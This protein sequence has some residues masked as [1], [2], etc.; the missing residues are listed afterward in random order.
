MPEPIDGRRCVITVVVG[1]RVGILRDVASAVADQDGV[2]DGISQTVVGGYFTA[3]LT[4]AFPGAVAP[5]EIRAAVAAAFGPGEAFIAVRPHARAAGDAPP[6]AGARYV[7]TIAG[8]NRPTVL[9]AVT[10][11]LARRGINIEDWNVMFDEPYVTHVG[12]ITVPRHMDIKQ[13]QD[14]FHHLMMQLG[15]TTC[16]QHENIFRATNEV[17]PITSLLKG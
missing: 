10:T 1:D 6:V 16:I 15:M 12:E 9:K 7:I 5:E 11:Y 14:E 3:T 4:A 17:G 2:I 13:V 8:P